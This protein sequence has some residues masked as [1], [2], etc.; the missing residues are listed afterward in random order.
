MAVFASGF[1]LGCGGRSPPVSEPDTADALETPGF[2]R[3][4]TADSGIDFTYRNGED[5][6]HFTI[7]ESLGG[8]VALLDFDGDGKLDVFLTA[9][10]SLDGKQIRGRP[11]KLFKN[12]GAGKFRD[13]SATALIPAETGWFY[14]HGAAVGD[15]DN[16]GW[17][18]LLVT[19][20]GRVA[21]FHNEPDGK[22]GRRL[23]ERTRDAGLGDF[24]WATGAA[25]GDLDGDGFA[26]LYIC[27]YVDWSFANHPFCGGYAGDVR[28]DVCPPK[29]FKA[30]PHRLFRNQG[31][32][33]FRDVS[34]EAGLREDGKGLGVLM[35]DVNAD[36]KPTSTLPTTLR[37]T[38]SI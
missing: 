19:G 5:A 4:I 12:L 22:G 26:D 30:V 38:F 29:K 2:F 15:Y 1:A 20:W 35:V 32:G 11:C 23:V 9:G 31:N 7:L 34:R 25:W 28:Q 16:D 36:G 18:D 37:T 27:Q 6:E 21:L 10:G 17:P 24:H 8:G 3:D 14:T 33:T 13:V